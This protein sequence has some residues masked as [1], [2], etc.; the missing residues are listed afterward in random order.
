MSEA[1]LERIQRE[2]HDLVVVGQ[3]AVPKPS[4]SLGSAARRLLEYANVSVAL[5]PSAS[6]A[7][8]R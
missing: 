2:G 8:P 5:A 4:G 7:A 1:I 3:R 6:F